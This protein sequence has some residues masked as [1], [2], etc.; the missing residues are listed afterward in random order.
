M[1][2]PIFEKKY[3]EDTRP[4]AAIEAAKAWRSDPSDENEAKARSAADAAAAAAAYAAAR[5]A[6]ADAV[7]G[8]VPWAAVEAALTKMETM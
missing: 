8:A 5:N 7:R 4:R 3:P 6:V 1:A 2:L